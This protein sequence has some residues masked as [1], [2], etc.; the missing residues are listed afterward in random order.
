MDTSANA[1]TESHRGP[2]SVWCWVSSAL[3]RPDDLSGAVGGDDENRGLGRRRPG[4]RCPCGGQGP[5][6]EVL[7]AV[8][9]V[10]VVQCGALAQEPAGIASR[11]RGTCQ[12]D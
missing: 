7:D 12:P 6:V 1:L 9:V 5:H 8:R 3:V 4:R 11:G 2:V 10:D